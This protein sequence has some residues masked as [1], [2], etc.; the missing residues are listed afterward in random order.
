[1]TMMVFVKIYKF[2]LSIIIF[3]STDYQW[4]F[5]YMYLWHYLRWLFQVRK[6]KK[7]SMQNLVVFNRNVIVL[8]VEIINYM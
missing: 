8:N 2:V 7:G 6:N 3:R 1:M 5:W 4:S